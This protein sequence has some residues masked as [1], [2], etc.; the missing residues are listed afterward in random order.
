M[1]RPSCSFCTSA[2]FSSGSTPAAPARDAERLGHPL[3]RRLGVARQDDR[4]DVHRLQP[5]HRGLRGRAQLV[6]ERDPAE[7]AAVVLHARP[8]VPPAGAFSLQKSRGPEPRRLALHHAGH[9]LA[10]DRAEILDRQQLA[11]VRL[12]D[13]ARQRMLGP[14]LQ[15]GGDAQQLF[16]VPASDTPETAGSPRVS[17]PVLSSTSVSSCFAASSAAALRIRMPARAAR[18]TP[19]ISAVGVARPSAHGQAMT[20]TDTA[21]IRPENERR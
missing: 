3:H 4:L 17:V 14:R 15:R 5:R 6:G 12:D 16:V 10:A 18:P 8:P 19:T 7:E 11:S 13:G 1:R 20:S 2:A 9:A 21:G